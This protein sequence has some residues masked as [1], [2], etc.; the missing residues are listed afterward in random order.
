MITATKTQYS[1]YKRKKRPTTITYSDFLRIK[2]EIVPSNEELERRKAYDERLKEISKNRAKKWPDSLEMKKKYQLEFTKRKFLEEENRRRKIDEEEAKFQKIQNNLV[3]ERAKNLL[4]M[5]Q[6]PVKRFNATMMYS[7]ML[8][9]REFQDD[10]KQKKKSI[11]DLIEKKFYEQ[12]LKKMEEFDK[13]ELEKKR[14]EE[15]KKLERMKIVNEQLQES[16]IKRIQDYQ[17]KIVEGE[18]M[19]IAM[20]KALEED[21]RK[22]EELNRLKAEQRQQFIDSNIEL[23]KLKEEKRKKELEEDKKIEEFAFKKQQLE[24]LRKKVENDKF[25]EKQAQRQKLID[26]Q[27]EYLTNLKNK[28]DARIEKSIKESEEKKQAEEKKKQD[29]FNMLQAE[30][31]QQREDVKRKKEEQK[32]KEKNEDM[33]FVEE[34]KNKMKLL[35]QQERDEKIAKKIRDKN[36]AEY[37]RLQLEEKKRIAKADFYKLNEDA[38]KI[39]YQLGKEDDDF[40]KYAEYWIREYKKQGKNINPMLLELKSYKKLNNFQ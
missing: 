31:K 32:L 20:K 38:Y 26:A 16:K 15:L 22:E 35:E 11:N 40:I 21:K 29:R 6:E 9:E 7:D 36:L 25:K 8:K 1:H 17:E 37:Q 13:K 5:E 14:L 24:D 34:W 12:E 18:L 19:K 3:V 30:I 10:I 28:E 33:K 23:E 4:F 27:I 2:N 39:K